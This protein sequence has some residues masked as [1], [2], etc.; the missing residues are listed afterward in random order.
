VR[1]KLYW[2]QTG[3]EAW[4]DYDRIFKLL[5]RAGRNGFV[6][7]AYEGW[8]DRDAPSRT[9][10]GEAPARLSGTEVDVPFSGNGNWPGGAGSPWAEADASGAR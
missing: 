8:Q 4:L 9:Q 1:A 7:L 2:L 6:S 5:R 3:K 10:R